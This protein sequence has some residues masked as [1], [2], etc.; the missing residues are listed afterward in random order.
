[1]LTNKDPPLQWNCFVL[2]QFQGSLHWKSGLGL[3]KWR[4]YK[5]DTTFYN[6][7][8]MTSTKFLS[9]MIRKGK[10]ISLCGG[11]ILGPEVNTQEYQMNVSGLG[12]V[13][14]GPLSLV[15][16]GD[17]STST[18]IRALCRVKTNA[19]TSTR[20]GKILILVLVL[21][22]ASRPFSRWKKH[23]YACA[24]ACIATENQALGT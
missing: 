15:F 8:P 5:I 22:L 10:I 1:M 16:T 7:Q 23:S 9:L 19:S 17:A 2:I 6:I 3:D 20:K 21:M 13:R 14:L 11:L 18:S 24:R 4:P 12:A